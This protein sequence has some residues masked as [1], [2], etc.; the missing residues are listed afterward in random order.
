MLLLPIIIDVGVDILM[1]INRK[2]IELLL[3]FH[4]SRRSGILRFE[5]GLT[6][7]QLVI[8]GGLLVFAESNLP[9]EHLAHIMVVMKILD[10]T[11]LKETIHQMKAGKTSE[12]AIRSFPK[13]GNHGLEQGRREQAITILSSLLGLDDY[14]MRFYPGEDLLRNQLNL[15]MRLSEFVL[16]SVRRAV[17]NNII[18]PPVELLSGNLEIHEDLTQKVSDLPLDNTEAY[19]LSLLKDGVNTADILPLIPVQSEK[20]E[21]VL[22]RFYALGLIN[23]KKTEEESTQLVQQLDEM[24]LRF[25]TS[26]PYEILSISAEATQ[27]EIQ[28]AYHEQAKQLHPDRF[29]TDE[30]S[31][32]IRENAQQIFVKINEAYLIL[33]NPDSRAI[34]ND[35]HSAATLQPKKETSKET[36]NP[37]ASAEALFLEGRDAL[38]AGD[39]ATAVDRL[40]ACVWLY[41]NKASFNHYLGVAESKIPKLRK[42]AEQHFLKA[43]EIQDTSADNHIE[44]AKIYIKVNLLRKAETQLNEAMRWDSD[45]A[46]V[47]KLFTELERLGHKRAV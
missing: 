26:T 15:Q 10:R 44:L 27:E 34:Y 7:K 24:L 22:L 1:S 40:K 38:A 18:K 2:L 36:L 23:F 37:D 45:N 32:E 39:I 42:S 46:E 28:A 31:A 29:Q 25:Q 13:P 3:D 47:L 16:V 41:P 4:K 33:K 11:Q 35:K 19:V 43:I 20:P 14:K 9:Q 8:N 21:N 5:K 30:F 17:S 6:K 12:E